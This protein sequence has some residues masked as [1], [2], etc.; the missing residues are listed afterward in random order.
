MGAKGRV[1]PGPAF[2]RKSICGRKSSLLL[3]PTDD[4]L[5]SAPYHAP[6]TLSTMCDCTT[7]ILVL[8]GTCNTL[9]VTPDPGLVQHDLR[10]VVIHY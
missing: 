8:K 1:D 4:S 10:Q 2:L 9:R 6:G 7:D 5:G 3:L